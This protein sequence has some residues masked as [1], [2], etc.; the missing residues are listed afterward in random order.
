MKT[1]YFLIFGLLFI[2]IKSQIG[3]NTQKPLANLEVHKSSLLTIP[4]GIIPP[5]TTADSLKMKDQLYG[6]PQNGAFIHIV[7]P[8]ASP[9]S[10]K[11]QNMTSS[12]YYIYDAHYTH[13]DKNTKGLWKKMFSDP[14]AFAAKGVSG[15]S[16][17]SSGTEFLGSDFKILQFNAQLEQEMGQEFVKDNQYVVP[18]TGLYA[19]NYSLR[20]GDGLT[21][22]VPASAKP[23]L[24]ISRTSDAGKVPTLLD[25]VLLANGTIPVIATKVSLTEGRIDHIYN[26]KT[27]EKLNFG[28]VTGGMDLSVLGDIST[29]I[30]IY[31]IR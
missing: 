26:L 16:L 7:A 12:G 15:L 23:G 13:A 9:A 8:L 27:G 1:I 2:N 25:H 5:R 6:P 21:K 18:E 10:P 17:V 31:K 22:D 3:I 20:F 28:V 24:A 30:S 14:S 4:D 19:I 29:E 11:T